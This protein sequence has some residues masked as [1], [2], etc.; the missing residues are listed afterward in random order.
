M[1][2]RQFYLKALVLAIAGIFLA[3]TVFAR[4]RT[5][6]KNTTVR[7]ENPKGSKNALVLPYAF[8]TDS[9][10]FTIGV[11]GLIKGYGQEQLLLGETALGSFDDAVGLFLGMWDY[12]PSWAQRFFLGAQGMA[13]HYPNQ[14]AY[15][16]PFYEPGTDRPGS[17]DSDKD[18]FSEESGYDNWS[19]FKLEYVLPLGSARNDAL[20]RYKLK[21]GSRSPQP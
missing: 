1:K 5:T 20:F 13:G 12:S 4:P 2:P 9:M 16:A 11:G 7:E 17:N 3:T 18:D 6:V 8:S 10:G 19:E 21:G 15:A 14:R